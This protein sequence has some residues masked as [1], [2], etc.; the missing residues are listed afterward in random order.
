M[1]IVWSFEYQTNLATRS[2]LKKKSNCML[3]WPICLA[4]VT[5]PC[6]LNI[7]QIYL[8]PSLASTMYN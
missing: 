1:S 3:F 2:K 4:N 5:L 7:W 8:K 6:N